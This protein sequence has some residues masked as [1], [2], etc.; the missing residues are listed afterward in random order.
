MASET[1]LPE[2]G[3]DYPRTLQE[4]DKWFSTEKA[5][6]DSI[7]RIRWPNGFVCPECK[8]CKGWQ[9]SSGLIRCSKCLRKVSILAGTTFHGTRKPLKLWFQ[10]MWYITSQ[11]FGGSASPKW[12]GRVR[13]Q[14]LPD[15]SSENLVPFI[16]NSVEPGST[17]YTD[18]WRG[19]NPLST[20]GYLHERI[21]LSEEND[22]AHVLMPEY[23]ELH[24]C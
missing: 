22:P 18:C 20:M 16:E 23:I 10:A 5:C 15:A 11:K 17:I 1:Q 8:S 21:N 19:Y 13:M 4:F 14:H 7:G 2:C 9:M 6:L 12:F 3:K 24:R